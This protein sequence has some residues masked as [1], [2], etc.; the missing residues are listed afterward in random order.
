MELLAPIT[1]D[2][3]QG[4]VGATTIHGLLA[5]DERKLLDLS[6]EQVLR[7]HR[8][9]LLSPIYAHLLSLGAIELLGSRAQAKS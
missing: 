5:V 9:S 4:D 7:L 8:E 6:D 2:F 3:R 1:I